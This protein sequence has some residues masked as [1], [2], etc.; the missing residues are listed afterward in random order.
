MISILIPMARPSFP[1][2]SKRGMAGLS[3]IEMLIS[4]ALGLVILAAVVNLFVNTSASRSEIERTSRQ[5]ENGRYAVDLLTSDLRLAGFYGELDVGTVA[6]PGALPDPCATSVA[7]L[8]AAI[9]MHI[10]GYN[11]GTGV[12]G[13]VPATKANTDVVV[14]RRTRGCVAGVAGCAAAVGGA[15]YM[16]VSLCDSEA[17]TT[18]YVLGLQG[19]ATFN[20]RIRDCTTAAGMRQYLEHIYFVSTDNGAGQNVPTLKRMEFT[21]G[22]FT[23][24]PLVEGIEFF[25]VNYG[26][27]TNGDG[28]VDVEHADPASYVCAGCTAITNWNNVITAQIYV[29]ARNIEPSP[30]YNDGKTYQL[31]ITAAGT[32]FT[33]GPFNDGFRRHVYTSTIRLVNQAGR[34]DTP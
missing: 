13:C 32:P 10:Q 24:T 2:R 21:G 4:M 31:G 16:Q 3:L 7:T 18:P 20:L 8:L 29:L 30:G 9:P 34:R 17:P 26:I 6:L 5:I 28:V 27:D 19:T 14:V 22:G 12:P 11:N 15:P 33:V 23:E 1:S 25:K